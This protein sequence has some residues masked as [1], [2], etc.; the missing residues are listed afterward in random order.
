[1]NAVQWLRKRAGVTQTRLAEL[2]ATSQPTI[3]AYEADRK[4]PTLR[5]LD[6]LA[7]AVGLTLAVDFVP[8]LTREDRR[9]LALH[10]AVADRLR[11]TPGA[12]LQRARRNLALL[13][14]KH[15]RAS[16]LWREWDVLLELPTPD[17]IDILQDPRPHARELR[18]VSPFAGVLGPA[19]RAEVYRRFRASEAQS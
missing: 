8:P 13:R 7:R 3:A 18:H 10:E 11:K 5:T 12:V 19:D 17:L 2:G 4:S 9:S 16:R 1:M 6:R 15:P 14:E